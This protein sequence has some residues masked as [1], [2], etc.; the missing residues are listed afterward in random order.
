MR[1]LRLALFSTVVLAPALLSAAV[2]K[3][4]TSEIPTPKFVPSSVQIAAGDTLRWYQIDGDH[5]ATSGTGS[6][7]PSAGLLFNG[8]ITI[9]TPTYDH[10]FNTPGVFHDFCIPHETFGMTGTVTVTP[11]VAAHVTAIDDGSPRFEPA[12]VTIQ[13]GQTVEWVWDSGD[14]TVT[15]GAGS[16]D[17]NAG[18]MLNS[19]LNMFVPAVQL[20][21][22]TAGTFPFF[23]VPHEFMDM[24]MTVKVI[25]PCSCPCAFDPRCD[26]VVSDVL[27]VSD[28][29][30]RAFRG[31][32]PNQDPA[33]PFER[34]DVDASGATDVLDVTKVINV[35]FRGNSAASQYD[36][37]PCN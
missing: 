21:F 37:N 12:T 28:T 18:L 4:G 27:D 3:V 32:A 7:D 26:G 8:S 19:S 11:A 25:P 1:N 14:H 20:T 16:S 2:V 13:Q 30:N 5:S 9:V 23:C 36:L 17:P 29:I 22:N 6:G 15:S 31:F 35:A 24:K 10:Q 34:T 33:C